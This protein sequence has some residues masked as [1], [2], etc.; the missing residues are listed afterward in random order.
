MSQTFK[1]EFYAA[2][3][4]ETNLRWMAAEMYPLH[5]RGCVIALAVGEI[6]EPTFNLFVYDMVFVGL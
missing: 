4:P 3:S 1:T 6:D 2:F 5:Y